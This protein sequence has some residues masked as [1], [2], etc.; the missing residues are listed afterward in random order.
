M[1]GVSRLIVHAKIVELPEEVGDGGDVTDFFVR[2]GSNAGDFEKL[3]TQATS[4][5]PEPESP[6]EAAH[7]VSRLDPLLRKH[8]ERIK[9]EIPIEQVIGSYVELRASGATTARSGRKI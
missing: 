2:L 3:L 4:A 5:P 6:P 7:P 8:V 1:V 9:R